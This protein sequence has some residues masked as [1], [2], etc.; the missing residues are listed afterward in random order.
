MLQAISFPVLGSAP[1]TWEGARAAGPRTGFVPLEEF[2]C[3]NAQPETEREREERREF[4]REY[5]Q[6]ARR[7]AKRIIVTARIAR[8]ARARTAH[9]VG[10]AKSTTSANDSDGEPPRELERVAVATVRPDGSP[11]TV[12]V[13]IDPLHIDPTAL[14]FVARRAAGH[15]L[16]SATCGLDDVRAELVHPYANGGAA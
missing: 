2:A 11:C 7:E 16:D 9:R 15:S 1:P 4:M 6:L 5:R 10:T 14:L 13:E 8:R 3:D 12:C